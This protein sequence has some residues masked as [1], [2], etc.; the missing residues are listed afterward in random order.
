MK[1]ITPD[2]PPPIHIITT[3]TTD[4]AFLACLSRVFRQLAE[5]WR[6][7]V[8]DG[9]CGGDLDRAI[10][11]DQERVVVCRRPLEA[12]EPLLCPPDDGLLWRIESGELWTAPQMES[13]RR[14]FQSAPTRTA[15]YVASRLFADDGS[16]LGMEDDA[17]VEP[18]VWRVRRGD[19]CLMDKPWRFLR[20]AGDGAWIDL[21]VADPFLPEETAMAGLVSQRYD[22]C[23]SPV[24]LSGGPDAKP[25]ARRDAGGNWRFNLTPPPPPRGR[26]PGTIRLA[27]EPSPRPRRIPVGGGGLGLP[28][29]QVRHAAVFRLDNIGDVVQT[30][31]FLREMRL[32]L[33][34]ARIVAFVSSTATEV[35]QPCPY[36]NQVVG[37]PQSTGLSP[38]HPQVEGIRD[39]IKRRF[40]GAFDLVLNPRAAEDHYH[41]ALYMEA[42]GA[43]LRI[44]Y[45]QPRSANGYDPEAH[46]THVVTSERNTA[47]PLMNAA[48]LEALTGRPVDPRLELWSL[49][50]HDAAAAAVLAEA[51]R[52]SGPF[53]LIGIG[54]SQPYRVWPLDRFAALCLR[55]L[56]RDITPVL[57]G[58]PADR[59]AA[60][61]ISEICAGRCLNT[62]GAT[63]LPVTAALMRHCD[64]FVGNDSGPKHMAAAVGVPVVEVGWIPRGSRHGDPCEGLA[65]VATFG[66]RDL[67]VE[68]PEGA[69]SGDEDILA[70]RTV[71]AVSVEAVEAAASRLLAEIWAAAPGFAETP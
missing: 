17:I 24:G 37:V 15:A 68:P 66:V 33:P 27:V 39:E 16:P 63:S 22:G 5:P 13:M 28:L 4:L 25:L 29:D 40:D 38:S 36:L 3:E 2:G 65:R 14:L 26:I 1:S 32:A 11:A 6:W 71:A 30:S 21:G 57:V 44:G 70:G 20:P 19:R 35:L 56:D 52:S 49:P 59:P 42:T 54:A 41:A 62:V 34:R 69:P 60:D 47:A 23:R 53:C 43:P 67:V 50:Q 48:F 10:A 46:L 64:L 61:R 9:E 45:R 12:A 58:G 51:P 7:F 18:R 8:F 31:G 55:L